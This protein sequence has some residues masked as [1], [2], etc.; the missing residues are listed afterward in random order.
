MPFMLV[1]ASDVADEGNGNCKLDT[2][3]SDESEVVVKGDGGTMR[4]G[5]LELV[6]GLKGMV[7]IGWK[8]PEDSA[9]SDAELVGARKMDCSTTSEIRCS[10]AKQ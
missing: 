9:E 5:A 2:D 10:S 4:F 8:I 6:V 3:G 1:C 7:D